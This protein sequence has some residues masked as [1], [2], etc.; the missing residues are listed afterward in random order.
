MTA[1]SAERDE[2]LKK[3]ADAEAVMRELQ[4]RV[5]KSSAMDASQTSTG[6]RGN[7][8]Q[9]MPEEERQVATNCDSL[10]VG[11]ATVCNA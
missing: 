11:T 1:V 3:A 10:S 6:V 2:A 4:G 7:G 5:Y 8:A 9:P